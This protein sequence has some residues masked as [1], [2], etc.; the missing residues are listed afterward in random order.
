MS[1]RAAPAPTI[2][3]VWVIQATYA[4]DAAETRVPHRPAHLARIAELK[5]AGTIVEAGAYLDMSGSLLIVR[6]A[7]EAAAIEVARQDVYMQQGVWVELRAMPFGR[8]RTEGA[9]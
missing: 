9:G 6:A 4:P 1:D 2:E 5:A 8:V 3:E 7:D